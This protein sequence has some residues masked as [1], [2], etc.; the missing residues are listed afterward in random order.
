M[1]LSAERKGYILN[2]LEAFLER[3]L[4]KVQSDVLY[5]QENIADEEKKSAR[6][7]YQRWREGRLTNLLAML[8]L[9][10]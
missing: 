1:E 10:R 8:T 5:I 9:L 7:S 2:D 3:E 6:L 4:E